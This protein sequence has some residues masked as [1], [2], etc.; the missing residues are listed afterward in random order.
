M[1]HHFILFIILSSLFMI[2]SCDKNNMVSVEEMLKEY[3]TIDGYKPHVIKV[4]EQKSEELL[5][6]E[7]IPGKIMV[8]D[9]NHY[10]LEGEF[11]QRTNSSGTPYFVFVSNGTV[12]STNMGCPKNDVREAFVSGSTIFTPYNSADPVVVYTPDGIE[13]KYRIW[14]AEKEMHP[15]GKNIENDI[16][17]DVAKELKHFPESL[18]GYDRYVLAMSHLSE[19]E[20]QKKDIKIELIPGKTEMVDCNKHRLNGSFTEKT[21]KGWGYKFFIFDSDGTYASTEMA[22]PDN[23]LT[24]Q[25]ICG[26]TYTIPYSSQ[27]PIVLFVPKGLEV[28]YRLVKTMKMEM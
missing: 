27:L 19:A 25:F 24:S 18:D 1:K 14:E 23:K 21:L 12:F 22:C 26:E 6:V 16:K 13:L 17:G 5:S 2:A 8:I 7:I 20:R 15:I 10:G 4:N 11:E 28:K 9:C 3:P